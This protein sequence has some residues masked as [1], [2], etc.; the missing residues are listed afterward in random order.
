MTNIR[1]LKKLKT[2]L[3]FKKTR[4]KN[5]KIGQRPPKSLCIL[6]KKLEFFFIIFFK[7]Q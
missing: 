3:A 2:L 6:F 1:K 4:K 7:N 5:E